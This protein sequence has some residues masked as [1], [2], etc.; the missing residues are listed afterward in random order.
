MVAFCKLKNLRNMLVH[1]NL[2]EEEC[3]EEEGQGN[4]K[5]GG[6]K[7]QKGGMKCRC[8]H[9][10]EER[11]V[12]EP[13]KVNGKEHIL[14]K[15][16]DCLSENLIYGIECSKCQKWY[17]GE[18][19]D[20]LRR[21]LNGHR[22]AIR[23]LEKIEQL[24]GERNDT[25]CAH[26]FHEDDHDLLEDAQLHILEKGNWSTSE[27]RKKE[28]FYICKIKSLKRNGLNKTAGVLSGLYEK[29]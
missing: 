5:C 16:G 29:I 12:G 6:W 4:E 25:G 3:K 22:A 7:S 23:R 26:H 17:I 14:R 1:S 21:R 9:H 24:D 8:C 2:K 27:R 11:K 13:I 18:T 28:S 10:V 20:S 15:G 19:G